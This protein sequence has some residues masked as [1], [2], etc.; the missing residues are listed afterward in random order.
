MTTDTTKTERVHVTAGQLPED[1]RALLLNSYG[2]A[3]DDSPDDFL[4]SI[5]VEMIRATPEVM[6]AFMWKMGL[7]V[8]MD[9]ERWPIIVAS[10]GRMV[11]GPKM[12]DRA[13]AEM[14]LSAH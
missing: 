11:C 1:L 8:H 2:P 9:L 6:E 10:M 14:A 5:P 12:Y 4:A 13:L 3:T 7:G